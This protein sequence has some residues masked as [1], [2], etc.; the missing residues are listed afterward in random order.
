MELQDKAKV[1]P[2]VWGAAFVQ[3]LAALTVLPWSIGK[4]RSNSSISC[5][6]KFFANC[7]KFPETQNQ[8][9][10]NIFA[11]SLNIKSKFGQIFCYFANRL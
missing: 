2:S 11:I 10:D 3:F 6:V 8:N 9:F 4:K 7:A 1:V 5:F